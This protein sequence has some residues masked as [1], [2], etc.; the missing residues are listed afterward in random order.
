MAHRFCRICEITELKINICFNES[1][2]NIRKIDEHKE[3]LNLIKDLKDLSITYGINEESILMKI[4]NFDVCK[5]LL[6]DTMHILY[7]GVCHRS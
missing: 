4:D 1:Q 5:C 7:E 3:C 2:V 6:L